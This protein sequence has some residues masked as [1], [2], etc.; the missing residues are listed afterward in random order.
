MAS[1]GSLLRS[2]ARL[3]SGPRLAMPSAHHVQL[4]AWLPGVASTCHGLQHLRAQTTVR[5]ATGNKA[6]KLATLDLVNVQF[7]VGPKD[8]TF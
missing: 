3:W 1:H 8:G 5:P 6:K 2:G 4:A 7:K